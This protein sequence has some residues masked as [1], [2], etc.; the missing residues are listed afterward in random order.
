M[1]F[2]WC[3]EAIMWIKVG[4]PPHFELESSLKF[5]RWTPPESP[6]HFQP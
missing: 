3:L 2:A 6:P 1:K 5:T 4:N